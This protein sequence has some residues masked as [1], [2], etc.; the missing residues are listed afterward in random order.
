MKKNYQ[1]GDI[2][3]YLLDEAYLNY[4]YPNILKNC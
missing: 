3:S 4:Y 1:M 2:T